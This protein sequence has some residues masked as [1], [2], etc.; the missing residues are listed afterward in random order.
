LMLS[1]DP[2]QRVRLTQCLVQLPGMGA[3]H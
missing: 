3:L 1:D 2:V